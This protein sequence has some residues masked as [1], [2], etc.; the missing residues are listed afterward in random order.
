VPIPGATARVNGLELVAEGAGG[1][2]HRIDTVLVRRLSTDEAHAQPEAR[3]ES[4]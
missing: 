1:R 2:R 4:A 3:V